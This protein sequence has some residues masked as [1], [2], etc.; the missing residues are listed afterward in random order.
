MDV[1]GIFS[2]LGI[3]GTKEENKIREAY[4]KKLASVNPEDNPEGFKRLRKAY[5][6]ALLL[7][8][9]PQEEEVL[10]DP[11]SLFLKKAQE[12]YRSLSRRLDEGEW[13]S[14]VREDVLDDLDLGEDAKWGLFSWLARC[15]RLPAGIWRILD[16]AFAIVAQENEFKEHLNG[17]FVDFMLWKIGEGAQE[18]D[19]PYEKFQGEDIADYDAFLDGFDALTKL[20]GTQEAQEE[21]AW[22]KEMGEKVAFL[23]SLGIGHPWFAMEKAKV[24]LLAGETQEAL[25]AANALLEQ[26]TGDVHILMAGAGILHKCGC[27]EQAAACYEQVLKAQGV[28]AERRYRAAIGLAEYYLAQEEFCKARENALAACRIYNTQQANEILEQVNSI[29]ISLYMDKPQ[30]LTREEGTRLAWCLIQSG[31]AADGWEFFETYPLLEEDLAECHW[32][33]T[34]LALESGHGVEAVSQTRGWRACIQR[35]YEG[36]AGKKDPDGGGLSGE[37]S[38]R[39]AQSHK[40]EGRAFQQLY[41]DLADKE[42]AEG[43]RYKENAVLAFEEAIALKPGELEFLMAKML[44]MRDLHD[45]EQMALLCERMRKL[46][47]GFFWACFYGQEAYE[48]LGKA[49]EVVDT[50]YDAKEIYDGRAEIYERAVRVFLAYRQY[51][52]AKHILDQADE[53]GVDSAFL[54]VKKAE[55][56][57]RLAADAIQLR[58]ADSYAGQAAARLE[59]M[60]ADRELLSEAYLQRCFVQDDERAQDFRSIDGMEEWAGRAVELADNNRT[61]YFLGRFYLEYREDAARC[62]EH[63]KLC[64][65][66]GLDFS[67]MY[68]YIARCHEEF[69]QW[70]EALRYFKLANEKDPEE[71]DFGWRVVWRLRWKFIETLQIEYCREAFSYLK[72]QNEKFGETPRELWQG[73]DMH[74]RLREYRTALDEIERALERDGQS[75]NLGHK[76]MLLEMLGRPLEAV[77]CYEKGI[78]SDQKKGRDYAY[79]YSQMYDYFCERKDYEGGI[80]WF[81]DKQQ[82][83][84]TKGQRRKNLDRLKYFY[85]QTGRYGD[86]VEII[87]AHY[88]STDLTDYA[89]DSWELEGER[90]EDLLD[91]YEETASR[92]DLQEK[93][94]QAA[95]LLDRE[96]AVGPAMHCEG[97]RR[98][99]SALGYTYLNYLDDAQNALGFFQKA[100]EQLNAQ[101]DDVDAEEYRTGLTNIMKCLWKLGRT[102]ET[103]PYRALFA[104][105]LEKEYKDCR[106]LGRTAEELYAGACGLERSHC[107]QLFGV[108]FFGG[109]MERARLYVARME[110]SG[111]CRYCSRSGCTEMWEVKGYLALACK[112]REAARQAFGNALD[113]AVRGNPDARREILAL[114]R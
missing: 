101:G 45:Y 80:A 16:R 11:V 63:L 14:L 77:A 95:M 35:E 31:R 83:L 61:R 110:N 74:A 105:S 57:R 3:A 20:T 85:L 51:K 22:K 86:A 10:G 30:E 94:G 90:L 56:L 103:A 4:R 73:S 33:K 112:D 78:E 59:E 21:A 29:L 104:Q 1:Q 89:C 15:Y 46:D 97:K 96:G 37:D 71:Q 40:L 98:A 64:Q 50:F 54:I 111:W 17:N 27:R 9:R 36:S 6:E 24:S 114:N 25:R 113:C 68:F 58:E 106:E 100:L 32:A 66:R 87:R 34:V 48:G 38:M 13:E 102:Q 8:R 75:R 109:D 81:L 2:V 42:T 91:Y 62:Y 70:D 44:F 76:G 72:V 5:E 53:A 79:A 26:E 65:E 84:L 88:G 18:T 7:A 60:Q 107:Y 43:I 23:E 92:Q 108:Y 41:A 28:G 12:I 67:W 93:A 49:Q 55:V 19:F 82:K 47:R 39:V 52:D 99:Y 69:Q